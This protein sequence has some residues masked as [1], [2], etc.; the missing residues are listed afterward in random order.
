MEKY[1]TIPE[2]LQVL[3]KDAN[4]NAQYNEQ[5]HM[6]GL[7]VESVL[8]ENLESYLHNF[9]GANMHINDLQVFLKGG[10]KIP[11]H[12]EFNMQIV[13]YKQNQ[14]QGTCR[15]YYNGQVLGV[16]LTDICVNDA[17]RESVTKL[18]QCL[19]QNIAK[20]Q[21]QIVQYVQQILQIHNITI[22]QLIATNTQYRQHY[23]LQLEKVIVPSLQ[24]VAVGKRVKVLV[25]NACAAIPA[26]S[27]VYKITSVT[28]KYVRLK[29]EDST[30]NGAKQ[31]VYATPIFCNMLGIQTT[32][33]C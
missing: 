7:Q 6:L 30:E 4:V 21:Q 19:Q 13:C 17:T 32:L 18:M 14:I 29:K 12:Y 1:Q 2:I 23:K 27:I 31:L 3:I 28:A 20:H 5:S 8:K 22:R 26:Q 33:F 15:Y 11:W 25:C 9:I 16:Y 10:A 24:K